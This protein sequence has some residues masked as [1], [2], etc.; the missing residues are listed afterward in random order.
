MFFIDDPLRRSTI[1]HECQSWPHQRHW[2]ARGVRTT[3][4]QRGHRLTTNPPYRNALSILSRVFRSNSARTHS[5]AARTSSSARSHSAKTRC[6]QPEVVSSSAL[7]RRAPAIRQFFWPSISRR[8]SPLKC[9]SPASPTW[10]YAT[11]SLLRL[12]SLARCA[13]PE[14]ISLI[15]RVF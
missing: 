11:E 3:H 10:L 2:R 12:V 4:R 6:D 8:L 15:R 14:Y 7:A 9:A 1:C 13:S 5:S